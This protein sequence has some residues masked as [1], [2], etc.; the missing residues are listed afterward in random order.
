MVPYTLKEAYLFSL[1]GKVEQGTGWTDR[2]QM[3]IDFTS[4]HSLPKHPPQPGLS[5]VKV[6]DLELCTGF[7]YRWQGTKHL[8]YLWLPLRMHQQEARWEAEQ[9]G[10]EPVLRYGTYISQAGSNTQHHNVCPNT[11]LL[12]IDC[13]CMLLPKAA[14]NI[15]SMIF[16]SIPVKINHRLFFFYQ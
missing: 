12:N 16:R 10:L 7:S 2:Q 8:S 15:L 6:R 11:T 13:Y 3:K 1:V 5:Q 14:G 4:A 9:Q